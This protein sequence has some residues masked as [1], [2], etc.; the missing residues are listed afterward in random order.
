MYNEAG[1]SI[2]TEADTRVLLANLV[3]VVVGEEHVGGQTALGSVGV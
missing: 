2:L 3:A 1:G